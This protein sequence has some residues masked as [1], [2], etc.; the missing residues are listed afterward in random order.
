VVTLCAISAVLGRMV[1]LRFPWDGDAGTFIYCGKAVAGGARF[2]HEIYDNKF[3]TAAL[4]NA[5][6]WRV[7]GLHWPAYVSGGRVDVARDGAHP[8]AHRRGG[9][10]GGGR[11]CRRC[12]VA[13][14]T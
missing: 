2:C 12:C 14:S 13:S 7:C 1:F 9:M 8:G 11:F 4:W 3:P 6:W 10:R 5:L